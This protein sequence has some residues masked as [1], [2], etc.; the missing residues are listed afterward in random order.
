MRRIGLAI[1][2]ALS[3][4]LAPIAGEAQAAGQRLP[5]IGYLSGGSDSPRDAAFR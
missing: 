3:L 1:A 4:F 5:R 2:L